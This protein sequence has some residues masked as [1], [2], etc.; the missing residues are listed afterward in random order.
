MGETEREILVAVRRL[1]AVVRSL[2]CLDPR[3]LAAFLIVLPFYVYP[4]PHGPPLDHWRG[5]TAGGGLN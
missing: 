4:H 3:S 2:F 5:D 1:P